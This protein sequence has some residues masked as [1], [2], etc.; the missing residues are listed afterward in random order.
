[1]PGEISKQKKN[2][3]GE[4]SKQKKTCLG[5]SVSKKNMPGEISKSKTQSSTAAALRANTEFFFVFSQC[6]SSEKCCLG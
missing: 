6:T 5:K 1:M 4:I 2:M 3:P